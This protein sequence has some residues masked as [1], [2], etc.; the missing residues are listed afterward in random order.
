LHCTCR[1]GSGTKARA[2]KSGKTCSQLYDGHAIDEAGNFVMPKPQSTNI[3][4]VKNAA[5]NVLRET[6]LIY[7]NTK[8]SDR[9]DTTRVR[10]HQRKF[11]Q[12]IYQYVVYLRNQIYKIPFRLRTY[13]MEQRKLNDQ[14]NTLVDFA[15]VRKRRGT[16]F[17]FHSDAITS[18]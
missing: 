14:A 2:D 12:A 15:K 13:K 1:R 4:K 9:V 10:K 3:H 16:R 11:L 5:A 7:K 6:W 17:K 18:L 8:L